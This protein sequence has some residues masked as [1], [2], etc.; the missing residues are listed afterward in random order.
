LRRLREL[1]A[2]DHGEYVVHLCDG[3]MLKLSRSYRER[4]QQALGTSL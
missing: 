3:T 2:R 4:L 1:R